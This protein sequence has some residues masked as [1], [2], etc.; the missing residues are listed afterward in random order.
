MTMLKQAMCL[1]AGLGLLSAEVSLAQQAGT[2]GQTVEVSHIHLGVRDIPSAL[3]WFDRV[4]R[5]KPAFHDG[6]MA[7]LPAKP[8]IILDKS[9]HDAVATLS[10]QSKDVDKDYER[11]V[12]RGAVSL[13]APNDKPYGVR[14]AYI[15]GPGSLTIELE[16][17]LKNPN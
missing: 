3:A 17:P 4:F 1:T 14:G 6:R 2:E 13:E 10:F 8:G 5:W 12:G 9:E 11:L 7:V 16:G 15:K